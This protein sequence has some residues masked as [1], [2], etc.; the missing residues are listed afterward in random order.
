MTDECKKEMNE[1][2]FNSL[3]SLDPKVEKAA[4]DA[5]SDYT[6]M[7]I[8]ERSYF[9]QLMGGPSY[10]DLAWL[11]RR[12]LELRLL[13]ATR[14]MRKGDYR[15]L[16]YYEKRMKHVGGHQQ[17]PAEDK[18][19]TWG[20]LAHHESVVLGILSQAGAANGQRADSQ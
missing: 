12:V 17:M 1:A 3:T 5:A 11:R 2:L 13:H 10:A 16:K 7:K 15:S 19:S 6:R 20:W 9:R 14:M 4:I 18:R 8:R